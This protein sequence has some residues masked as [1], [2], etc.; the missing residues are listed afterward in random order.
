MM[1]DPPPSCDLQSLTNLEVDRSTEFGYLNGQ[2]LLLY[3]FP[4][5]VDHSVGAW[6]PRGR[7]NFQP[8]H[9]CCA[10]MGF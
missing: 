6:R 10:P 2:V 8:P 5:L 7:F 1:S 3:V 4:W 9:A